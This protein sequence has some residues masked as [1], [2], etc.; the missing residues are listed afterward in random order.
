MMKSVKKIFASRLGGRAAIGV[1]VLAACLVLNTSVPVVLATPS[2]GTFTVGT[3]TIDYGTNTAVTVNQAQSVIQWGTAGSGGIDTSST[4]SLTFS[5]A[6]GLSNSAVLNRAVLNRIMS[7]NPTQFDG[8][9]NGAD[10]RIFIVNPA[11]IVFGSGSQI[12]VSQL[13]ASGLNMSDA[14]FLNAT[15]ASP[16]EFRFEGGSGTVK[17]YGV[18]KSNGVILV[19]KKVLNGGA[20]VA[21]SGLVVLA[22]G[23]NVYLA[24][25][26][27]SVVV[28]IL[29]DPHDST[30]D[31]QNRSVIN[32]ASGKIV[33]AAGDTFSRAITNVGVLAASSGTIEAHAAQIENRGVID[34][35]AGSSSDGDGGT[36][37]L[38]GTE[39]VLVGVDGLGN[40]GRITANAGVNGT[41]G[42]ITL[43]S[44]QGTVTVGA[45]SLLSAT[46]GSTSRN[47]G[48][49]KI[50]G[51]H[52]TLAG[53]VDASPANKDYNPGTLEIDAP[54]ATIANGANA[55]AP[56]TL[57]EQDIETWGSKGTS[58]AVYANDASGG[59]TVQDITDDKIT[60]R[61]G[62]IDLYATGADSS[63][64]FADPTDTISTTLGD[65][66]MSAGSG[67]LNIGN[68]ET[69]L[70]A[71]SAKP[72]P[73]QIA[74]STH[75]GGD[76][77][78]GNLTI[79]SGWGDAEI[80]VDA[81]GN[82]TVNGDVAVG[83]DTPIQNVPN[84]QNG[85]A[86]VNLKAGNNV[87]LNGTVSAYAQGI[88]DNITQGDVTKAYIGIFSGANQ[89]D[90]NGD[91]FINGNLVANAQ[92]STEGTSDAKI[93]VNAWGNIT[94]AP[95]VTADAIADGT[96]VGPGT[97]S[98][99]KTDTSGNHAQIIVTPQGYP[100]PPVIG[101]DDTISA[102][103]DSSSIT[104][105]VL[106]NDT[107]GGT[108][109]ADVGG[110]IS[111][112]TQPTAGTLT[113]VLD[114]SGNIVS[115]TYTP[116]ADMTTLTFNAQGQATV[117]FTYVA[118]VNGQL[119]GTTTATITL[120]NGLPVAVADTAST[121]ED[122]QVT[123][124][125]L[126][127]D[128][129]P[130][131][132]PLSTTVVG[133]PA[134]GTVVQNA[135]GTLT[136]TPAQG[137]VGPD[138][139]TY[140]ATDS[141]NTSGVQSVNLTVAVPAVSPVAPGLEPVK[142][143]VSGCPALVRWAAQ[144][145]GVKERAVQIWIANAT[146]SAMDI[147]PCD[148]CASLKHDAMILQDPDGKYIAALARVVKEFASGTTP[149]T[150]EQMASIAE[151]L[152]RNAGADNQ[153]ATAGEYLDA[154]AD[155]VSILNSEMGLSAQ[156]AVQFAS[157]KYGTRLA[158]SG[159][160]A[161]TAYVTARL[162]ALAGR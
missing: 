107:Q 16:T 146:A 109:L 150:E 93:E 64:T 37:N 152:A 116:P 21:P 10:M 136:Y 70:D 129:D 110:V 22:A 112:Y 6:A 90:T 81:A 78:T 153:Y 80:N 47:G 74:L 147:Q 120:I 99:E 101:V 12:N 57:Y 156:E 34:V 67:G 1:C 54:S 83:R 71:S 14:D 50:A 87:T 68:L 73:G 51:T 75:D 18:I 76:I 135:N 118:E 115:F 24:Q 96:E 95:G 7:G 88:D 26:G 113:P 103:K 56:D 145:L 25:D 94:F 82:L 2:G 161:V 65:I 13:V 149:P 144:E 89:S 40:P 30:A 58:L 19:G 141:L 15:G 140:S 158:Q 123:I 159:N 36:V 85:E 72:I 125:V 43:D 32:A 100:L 111:S 97:T 46:G 160:A 162:A 84:G 33:L 133:N 62:D 117:T 27:S 155:Y 124:N 86:V 42:N 3:G 102:S 23:D 49:V 104:V 157:D 151:A 132:D 4:E 114:S 35:S 48:S 98:D 8:I 60:G 44:H 52:F 9:L 20:I 127:N 39:E 31:V 77:T 148:T 106:S 131:A 122:V 61:Y 143:E 79:T 142:F 119:S 128:T 154:L 55:G 29:A 38:D 134:H 137:Y 41:G 130:D 121:F 63:I 126:A 139:F 45:G 66:K 11:G 108:S 59:I 53:Q 28:Q 91:A 17:N 92:S 69:G 105:D 138:S 5:Q